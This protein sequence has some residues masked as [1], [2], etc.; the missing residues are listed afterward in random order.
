MGHLVRGIWR[1]AKWLGV[2]LVAAALIV[3]G[4]VALTEW[5][6]GGVRAV[7]APAT[8]SLLAPADRRDEVN[9]YLTYP[10]WSIVYAYEDLAGVIGKGSES[11]FDYWNSVE[12][13]WASLC[14]VRRTALS[15]GPIS[16]DYNAMLY[17]IGL[18]FTAEM[19]VKAAWEKTIGWVTAAIRGDAPTPED[20]FAH[21][22]AVD[23]AQ[24][25]RQVPWYEYPFGKKLAQFW[26]ETPLMGGNPIR[27]IERR[28]AL[29]LEYGVKSIYARGIAALAGLS[30]AQLQIRSIV[31]AADVT[32]IRV[33]NV[34]L[35][36]EVRPGVFEVETP[37]YRAF[38]DI[39]RQLAVRGVDF[40]EIAGN[41]Q[42]FVTALLPPDEVGEAVGRS[43]LVVMPIQSRP[44]WRRVGYDVEVERLTELLRRLAATSV[45][46]EHI[47]DY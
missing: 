26:T 25:L 35:V 37:R 17:I 40:E 1:V 13:F 19:G 18:S 47:Y 6:C 14:S 12:G 31:R 33:G 29:S 30:P 44:G 22:L 36:R 16:F 38:T 20:R 34:R 43:K 11:D 39:I 3:G 24:F 7:L 5:R 45:E 8:P 9:T 23:Y 46:L 28:V 15:R 42:I 2:L 21:A 10:E 41:R 27:K 4:T 32:A